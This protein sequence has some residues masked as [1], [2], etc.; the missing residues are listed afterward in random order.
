M[1]SLVFGFWRSGDLLPTPRADGPGEPRKL[2]NSNNCVAN[3]H[4]ILGASN[5]NALP[6]SIVCG[7]FENQRFKNICR[8]FLGNFK[9]FFETFGI[10]SL[11]IEKSADMSRVNRARSLWVLLV[12][13]R[14]FVPC[15]SKT[16]L[17]NF[18]Y[19]FISWPWCNNSLCPDFLSHLIL[20]LTNFNSGF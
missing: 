2:A 19:N 9:L 14:K 12:A 11:P 20:C 18:L 7:F 10:C 6:Y 15:S 16:F 17:H 1:C 13:W 4:R 8:Q 3:K 5:R